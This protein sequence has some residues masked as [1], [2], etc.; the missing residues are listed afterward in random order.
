MLTAWELASGALAEMAPARRAQQLPDALWIDL[1][2]PDEAEIARVERGLALA[3]PRREDLREI[4]PSSRIYRDAAG[5]HLTVLAASGLR[6]HRPAAHPVGFILTDGGQLITLRFSDLPPLPAATVAASLQELGAGGDAARPTLAITL[7]LTILGRMIDQL[8]DWL[9]YLSG[10]I[11]RIGG[12][13]FDFGGEHSANRLALAELEQL[14]KETGF[15]Q[16]ALNKLRESLQTLNRVL[17]FLLSPPGGRHSLALP[18]AGSAA[19]QS[20][21]QDTTSLTNQTD[22]LMQNVEFLLDSATG[23]ISIE[24]NA[25]MKALSVVSV[26][27]LPP[28]LIGAIYG[29]NFAH[30]PELTLRYAYPATLVA[31]LAAAIFPLWFFR[32]KGWL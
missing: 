31:M 4:E 12:R 28:T 27:L 19:L 11:D 15:V 17:I 32:R 25:V 22:Y 14:L 7:L 6:D 13:I 20:L 24:Q 16:F 2:N 3:L 9:E 29:M 5:Q 21:M 23:R 8:A 1:A 30:M 10:E 18:P 26:C